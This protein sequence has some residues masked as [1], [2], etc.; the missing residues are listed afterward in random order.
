LS[1]FNTYTGA[2]TI[3]PGA[4]LMLSGL[5][6]ISNSSVVTANG[7]FDI[8]GAIPFNPIRTLAGSGV[9]QLGSNGLVI[10]AGA[11]EFSGTIAGGP[12]G[13]IEILGGTQTLSGVNTYGGVTQ[14][15]LGATLALKGNGS[16]ANTLYVGFL[17]AGTL[18]ISQTKS[19]ASISGLFDPVGFGKVSLGSKTLTFTSN[20]GFFHGV[21][22]RMAASAAAPAAM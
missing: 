15:D 13:G 2:T 14:I 19:G 22:H 11:T 17:G 12:A 6:G 18:D 8:S 3:N 16:I 21:I 1:A 7:T 5:A 20:V 10:T 9:V 4:T